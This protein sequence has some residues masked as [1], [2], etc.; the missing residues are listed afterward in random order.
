MSCT[1]SRGWRWYQR[2]FLGTA[3]G[4]GLLL[5]LAGAI[6]QGGA[7][8]L[9]VIGAAW[10]AIG[11]V[12]LRHERRTAHELRLD[13][14]QV[15]FVFPGR[16]LR[17][18]AGEVL[19]IRRGRHDPSRMRPLLVLTSSHGVIKISPRLTGLFDF[20]VGLRQANPHV[21]VPNL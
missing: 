17:M 21:A 11:A 3:L 20:L 8:A 4:G 5:F 6:A 2:A 13:E 14:G 18:P 10:I 7:I 12:G 1:T 19:A 9:L 16:E 15:T